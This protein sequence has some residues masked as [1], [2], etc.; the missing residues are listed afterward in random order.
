L[1]DKRSEEGGQG[2]QSVTFT[3]N[4]ESDSIARR[5]QKRTRKVIKRRIK[6]INMAH[7]WLRLMVEGNMV[8]EIMRLIVSFT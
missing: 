6:T 3:G 1:R 2:L 7:E 5:V 8:K 4:P